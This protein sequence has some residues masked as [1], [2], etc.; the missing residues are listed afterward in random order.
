MNI[1]ISAHGHG[2]P[3]VLFHGWGFDSNIWNPLLPELSEKYRLY[4]VDLPGFGSTTA[5]PWDEFKAGLLEKLPN[6]FAV[7]GW[8]MGGLYATRLVVEESKRITHLINICSSPHFIRK[9]DWPGVGA[10]VID[11]FYRD[12]VNRPEQTLKDFINLQLSGQ[13]MPHVAVGQ[14]PTIAGLQKGLELLINW[15]MRQ[16]IKPLSLPVCYMFGRLDAITPHLTMTTMQKNYPQFNY[17]MFAKAAH[18]PFLSNS[19]EFIV[20]LEGFVK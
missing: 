5:M 17:L 11:R 4:L 19:A 3:L 2:R 15:D 12:L 20:A 7:A 18:V 13:K 6:E 1:N 8:S 10:E 16:D 9:N 14:P